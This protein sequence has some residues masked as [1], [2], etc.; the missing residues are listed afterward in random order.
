M[1]HVGHTTATELE[2]NIGRLV[3]LGRIIPA[4]NHFLSRLRD[5]QRRAKTRRII[6]LTDDCKKDIALM[7][8]FLGKANEGIDLNLISYRSPNHAYRGDAC[9]F[10]LGG[11]T[12]LGWAWR[13]YIPIYL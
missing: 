3:H 13:F 2:K 12:N 8:C 9:P 10:G 6:K 7:L 1:L 11:Y 4:V 5:L